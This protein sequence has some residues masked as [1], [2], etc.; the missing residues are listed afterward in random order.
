M[1]LVLTSNPRV[2]PYA[3][4]VCNPAADNYVGLFVLPYRQTASG[5][6]FS[7]MLFKTVICTTKKLKNKAVL[8]LRKT[9][10]YEHSV[11]LIAYSHLKGTLK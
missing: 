6:C 3:N 2:V 11:L 5:Y 4:Y 7:K 9:I 1:S 10:L 8:N